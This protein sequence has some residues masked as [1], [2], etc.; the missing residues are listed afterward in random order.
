M[1]RTFDEASAWAWSEAHNP[2]GVKRSWA[3]LCQA[4]MF[5]SG[6]FAHSYHNAIAA[7]DASGWLNPDMTAAPRGAAVYWHGVY[8]DGHVAWVAEAGADPLLLM[9]S[10]STDTPW[11][12]GIGLIRLSAYQRRFGWPLRGWSLRNGVF[13]LAGVGSSTAGGD[14][15]PIIPPPTPQPAYEEDD[16]L[17]FIPDA[18]SDTIWLHNNNTGRTIGIGSPYHL[19]LLDRAQKNRGGD[20]MLKIE[21]DIVAE[22]QL[23]VSEPDVDMADIIRRLDAITV[24]PRALAEALKQTGVTLTGAASSEQVASLA[25]QVQ[26]LLAKPEVGAEAIEA[27]LRAVLGE[28]FEVTANLPDQQLSELV[29]RLAKLIGIRL[30]GGDLS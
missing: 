24:T 26:A 16:M 6:G 30:A 11:G 18:Q 1:T 4:F 21:I 2:N 19:T 9:A 5:W 23:A 3:G 27:G 15:S 10:G 17:S 20:R 25:Q 7:G 14:R 8:G 12:K 13:Q 29:L 22:Y 28:G